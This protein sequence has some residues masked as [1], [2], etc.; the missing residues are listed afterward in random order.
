[1]PTEPSDRRV[2][3]WTSA[4]SPWTRALAGGPP[5]GSARAP[6]FPRRPRGQSAV[7]RRRGLRPMT[8]RR[9]P[10][11]SRGRGGDE[12]SDASW[13]RRPKGHSTWI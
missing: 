12:T 8:C 2:R 13:P 10:A 4:R 11:R 1:M 9:A 3:H 5:G 6:H 7:A